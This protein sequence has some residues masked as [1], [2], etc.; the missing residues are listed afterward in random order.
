MLT[1]TLSLLVLCYAGDGRPVEELK[2]K[3]KD[4]LIEYLHSKDLAEAA[5]C[6]HEMNVPLFHHEVWM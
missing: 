2:G 6:I 4:T 3:V 5:R 1:Q